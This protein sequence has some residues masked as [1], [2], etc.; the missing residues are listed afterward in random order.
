[1][2][3]WPWTP[4]NTIFKPHGLF[5]WPKEKIAM[6]SRFISVLLFNVFLEILRTTEM[7]HFCIW[8][9]V[10][11]NLFFLKRHIP[12]QTSQ[13]Q[14]ACMKIYRQWKKLENFGIGIESTTSW[15]NPYTCFG[16]FKISESHLDMTWVSFFS[17]IFFFLF[18][19]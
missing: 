9:F 11:W 18:L 8:I 14:N 16:Y 3:T 15:R 6:S 13:S 7:K 2:E 5:F 19:F 12:N 1:M 4:V 10:R 17:F